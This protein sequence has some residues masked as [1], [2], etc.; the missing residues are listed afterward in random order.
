M[1]TVVCHIY[2]E[3]ILLPH[4]L[5]HHVKIFDKGVIIDYASTDSSLD[6]VRE[7]A[8]HWKIV[9][10]KNQFF[11]SFLI[12]QEVMEV[13]RTI[14]EWKMTLNCTEFILK[15]NLG[16]YIDSFDL[17][18]GGVIKAI[19]T[20]GVILVDDP[21]EVNVKLTDEPLILQRHHGFF[22]SEKCPIIVRKVPTA[23]EAGCQRQRLI[24]KHPD[25][26]YGPGRHFTFHKFY[27][28]PSLLL[29]WF[30]LSPFLINRERKM[31][32]FER[33]S[34]E[35]KVRG[36]DT[37]VISKPEEFDHY[38]ECMLPYSENLLDKE[39]YSNAIRSFECVS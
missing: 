2:N 33:M 9:Q 32:I 15:P 11:D 18:F 23:I 17:Q 26:A 36:K 3:E 39:S 28:D 8:P 5:K 25:G 34:K 35:D 30:G 14:P 4:W 22:E 7:I 12:D 1:I 37:W 21:K 24:H 27:S 16:Q 19:K 38:Y 31:Q 6:I 20:N 13:E 10:S 29:A